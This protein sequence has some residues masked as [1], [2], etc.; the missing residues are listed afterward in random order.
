MMNGPGDGGIA[1]SQLRSAMSA[2]GQRPT[3]AE[4]QDLMLDFPDGSMPFLAFVAIMSQRLREDDEE[5]FVEEFKQWHEPDGNG[6]V[7]VEDVRHILA[8]SGENLSDDEV[9]EMIREVGVSDAGQV[10]YEELV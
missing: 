9:E 8:N 10:N 6:F 2:L 3:E 7:S 4:L 1:A 5:S